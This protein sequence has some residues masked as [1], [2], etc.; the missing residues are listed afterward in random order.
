MGAR[1]SSAQA[2][3]SRAPKLLFPPANT[4]V[5][6]AMPV[7]AH[8][9]DVFV[10]VGQ[11]RPEKN[12]TMQLRAF[13][14][15]KKQQS[16]GS[17]P[18][19]PLPA[20]AR[21]V[22]I[23]GARNAEDNARVDELAALAISLGLG[24]FVLRR[25]DATTLSPSAAAAVAANDDAQARAV[26]DE[27]Q[28]TAGNAAVIFLVNAPFSL[29]R[30]VMAVAVAGVHTMPNEHFGIVVVEYMAAGCVAIAHRSA[31]PEMILRGGEYGFL[32]AT[33]EEFSD[34]MRRAA[35]MRK[36]KP[37]EWRALVERAREAASKYGDGGFAERFFDDV[38][39][40]TVRRA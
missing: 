25:Y 37:E 38:E 7:A 14:Q 35:G 19:P 10:S 21:L 28:A 20:S 15:A 29:L 34:A 16:S 23:G 27:V 22:L 13:A 30:A 11:F 24:A 26:W 6:G 33:D 9:A 32:G 39:A 8:G 1:D 31:G 36:T 18:P 3:G 4:D 5:Y 12:H 17:M 40:V 2:I